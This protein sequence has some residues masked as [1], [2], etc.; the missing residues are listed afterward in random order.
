MKEGK[1]YRGFEKFQV[2]QCSESVAPKFNTRRSFC[3]ESL[4]IDSQTAVTGRSGKKTL[5]FLQ[6]SVEI[7]PKIE[8]FSQRFGKW[9]PIHFTSCQTRAKIPT[10]DT[11]HGPIARRKVSWFFV[12]WSKLPSGTACLIFYYLIQSTSQ[13]CHLTDTLAATRPNL[14]R[15]EINGQSGR[16]KKTQGQ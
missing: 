10:V 14:Q 7:P 15:D 13:V 6:R 9:T 2:C 12:T 8:D 11:L 3:I 4:E 5:T 16:H 1:E